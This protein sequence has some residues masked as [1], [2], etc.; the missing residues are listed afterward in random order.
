LIESGGGPPLLAENKNAWKDYYKFAFVRN[1]FDFLVS[2]F[3]WIR[4]NTGHDMCD[5]LNSMTFND[6][7]RII[8]TPELQPDTFIHG[9]ARTFRRP[10]SM[11][12]QDE[13]GQCILDY[14][15][16]L[17]TIDRQF[18]EICDILSIPNTLGRYNKSIRP[19]KYRDCYTKEGRAIVEKVFQRDFE[20]FG[21]EF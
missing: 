17:E 7:L 5:Y 4:M 12:V 20:V 6:F 21:Y 10:L 1:P 13:H 11:F 16:N 9:H 3:Y 14:V 18:Q 2:L 15:G 19:K 8:E